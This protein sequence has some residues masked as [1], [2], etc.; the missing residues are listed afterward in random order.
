M[1]RTREG[2]STY[3]VCDCGRIRG[4]A[5][6]GEGKKGR[7][8]MMDRSKQGAL[9]YVPGSVRTVTW[10][11]GMSVVQGLQTDD[12]LTRART[13]IQNIWIASQLQHTMLR[14]IL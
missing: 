9:I 14:L 10:Y 13:E 11:F 1:R 8:G 3:H 4:K 6:S 2:E 5:G 12:Q 7:K